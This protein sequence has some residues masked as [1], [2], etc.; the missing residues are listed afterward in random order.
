MAAC[1]RK[2]QQWGG[3][4]DGYLTHQ[5]SLEHV[6]WVLD[7]LQIS[8]E[9]K[10][11]FFAE[12]QHVEPQSAHEYA[13]MLMSQA[14]DQTMSSFKLSKEKTTREKGIQ[15]IEQIKQKYRNKLD[16]LDGETF[17]MERKERRDLIY[18][19][20]VAESSIREQFCQRG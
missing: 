9:R 11:G 4:I 20:K 5:Y 17:V 3:I 12:I 6:E 8:L 10:S 19:I 2:D 14:F 18:W 15:Y 13:N 7:Q 16:I 1:G